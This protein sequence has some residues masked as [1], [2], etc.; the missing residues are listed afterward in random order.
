MVRVPTLATAATWPG[1]EPAAVSALVLG[2]RL[3]RTL[4]HPQLFP[5]TAG[6]GVSV[7]LLSSP[8]ELFENALVEV[9]ERH[10]LPFTPPPTRRGIALRGRVHPEE[11]GGPDEVQALGGG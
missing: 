8:P 2:V 4:K 1:Y 11:G 3:A 7:D 10:E 5:Q 9:L 6:E